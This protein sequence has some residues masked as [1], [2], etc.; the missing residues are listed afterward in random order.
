MGGRWDAGVVCKVV[1][2]MQCRCSAGAVLGEGAIHHIAKTT[3]LGTNFRPASV[4][5]MI[6][7]TP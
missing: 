6:S 1:C 4:G 7:T 2:S 5:I 3:G